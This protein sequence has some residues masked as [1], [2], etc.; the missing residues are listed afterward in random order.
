MNVLKC[1]QLKENTGIG[2][3]GEITKKA[4]QRKEKYDK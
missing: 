3:F 1:T 4:F 2:T